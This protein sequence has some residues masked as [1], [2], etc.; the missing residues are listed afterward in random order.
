MCFRAGNFEM[1]EKKPQDI[2]AAKFHHRAQIDWLR[3]QHHDSKTETSLILQLI[4]K[5]EH[6]TPY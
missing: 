3:Y 5:S 4:P 1:S 6:M 2:E